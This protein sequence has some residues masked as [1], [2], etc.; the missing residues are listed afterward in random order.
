[1]YSCVERVLYKTSGSVRNSVCLYSIFNEKSRLIGL[2]SAANWP[3]HG[4]FTYL[5]KRELCFW[6]GKVA[7]GETR[8]LKPHG[9]K[10][11]KTNE[12]EYGYWYPSDCYSVLC[13]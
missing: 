13:I 7:H 1:M 11:I 8:E 5:P 9:S 6:W 3:K 12:P 2:S 4:H 10:N